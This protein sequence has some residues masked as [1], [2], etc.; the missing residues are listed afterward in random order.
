MKDSKVNPEEQVYKDMKYDTLPDSTPRR[1]GGDD[2][3]AETFVNDNASDIIPQ[4][5]NEIRPDK[6]MV[7]I[8]PNK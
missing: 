2:A 1:E 8:Q 5:K 3:I 7:Q 4:K 6:D